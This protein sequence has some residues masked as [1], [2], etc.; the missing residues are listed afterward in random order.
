MAADG[1]VEP[2]RFD[3]QLGPELEV[4]MAEH[5][6]EVD[7]IADGAWPPA[8]KDTIAALERSGQRLHVAE[9]VFGATRRPRGRPRR[10]ARSR[11]RSRRS[12]AAA[13]AS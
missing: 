13:P 5:R 12:S 3:V 8:F 10:P 2:L 4:A 9:R 11:A 7:A 6:A 1:A